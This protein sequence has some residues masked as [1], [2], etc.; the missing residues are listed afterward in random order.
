MS[1]TSVNMLYIWKLHTPV[2]VVQFIGETEL[3]VTGQPHI[4]EPG[5]IQYMITI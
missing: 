2:K 1:G 4:S 5:L 3:F